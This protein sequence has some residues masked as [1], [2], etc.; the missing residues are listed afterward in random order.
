MGLTCGPK[1]I[2]FHLGASETL[3]A[4]IFLRFGI[5][6]HADPVLATMKSLVAPRW[7]RYARLLRK[8]RDYLARKPISGQQ[9]Y[10]LCKTEMVRDSVLYNATRVHTLRQ[11]RRRRFL[12]RFQRGRLCGGPTSFTRR[13]PR[14][15][16]K[17][18]RLHR[19]ILTKDDGADVTGH[20]VQPTLA[21]PTRPRVPP[22]TLQYVQYLH[23]SYGTAQHRAPLH[24][25]RAR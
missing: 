2:R 10:C 22:R 6:A 23:T 20:T 9:T 24:I 19:R 8:R 1:I 15:Q 25:Y 7:L 5:N 14:F 4:R 17:H 3:L 16:R 13:G 18:F 21:E 12:H 11:R